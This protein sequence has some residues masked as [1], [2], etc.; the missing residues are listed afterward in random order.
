MWLK[1]SKGSY[2]KDREETQEIQNLGAE[3]V[4]T[5]KELKEQT[6]VKYYY[7]IIHKLFTNSLN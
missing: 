4:Y 2:K 7:K 6:S 3:V 1:I 5:T